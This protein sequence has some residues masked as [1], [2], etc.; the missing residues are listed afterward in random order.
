MHYTRFMLMTAVAVAMLTQSVPYLAATLTCG[1]SQADFSQDGSAAFE[2]SWDSAENTSAC[3]LASDCVLE[4]DRI[5]LV[6]T[7]HNENLTEAV[8]RTECHL[9]V[10]VFVESTG[11]LVV[12][13]SDP[14]KMDLTDFAWCRVDGIRAGDNVRIGLDFSNLDCDLMAWW[15]D[16]DNATWTY[17]NNLVGASMSTMLHPEYGD[18]MSDRTGSLALGVFNSAHETG[19]YTVTVDTRAGIDCGSVS[20]TAWKSV[21]P[22]I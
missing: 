18:F 12:P 11:E 14:S 19:N 3:Q 20:G 21:P 5:I 15:A 7:F 22:T 16:T 13:D 1:V 17:E 8:I 2:G 9:T 10:G 4:G 6:G